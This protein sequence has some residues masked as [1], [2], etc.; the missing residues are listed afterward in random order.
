MDAVAGTVLDAAFSQNA[1]AASHNVVHPRP[2]SWSQMIKHVQNSLKKVIQRDVL[3]VP[4][5]DW[6][7][8]LEA[9]ANQPDVSAKDVVSSLV[10]AYIRLDLTLF[11]SLA[12]SSSSSS[13][14]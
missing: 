5:A 10:P 1:L 7:T 12:S 4:F 3:I 13:A 11:G 6:F 2:G 8:K 9:A 14:A